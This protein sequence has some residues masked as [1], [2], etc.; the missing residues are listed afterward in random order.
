MSYITYEMMQDLKKVNFRFPA[1]EHFL[2]YGMRY[3][4]QGDEHVIGGK[5]LSDFS[6]MDRLA[7]MD[8]CLLPTDSQ[9]LQWLALVEIDG[10]KIDG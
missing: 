10:L 7:A 9:L 6:D 8:G 2:N 1:Y 3:Y 5:N 4:Y